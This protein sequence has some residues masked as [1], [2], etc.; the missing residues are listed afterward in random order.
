MK[1][2]AAGQPL[3]GDQLG[4]VTH[5]C[6]G[7]AGVDAPAVTQ[8]RTGSTLTVVAAFLGAGQVQMLTQQVKQRGPRV[9]LQRPG[10]AI[11]GQAYGVRFDTFRGNRAHGKSSRLGARAVGCVYLL[12]L[13]LPGKR[14]AYLPRRRS[15]LARP[16]RVKPAWARD[17]NPA[18]AARL[19]RIPSA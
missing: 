5:H 9:D 3:D 2:L 8:H 16:P 19:T 13:T 6:Q 17:W 15:L 7:Q 4:A 1:L 14:S 10:V 12:R 18:S 11:E